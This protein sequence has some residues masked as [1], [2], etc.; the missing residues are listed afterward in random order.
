M[1]LVIGWCL[2]RVASIHTFSQRVWI[3]LYLILYGQNHG[4]RVQAF[5]LSFFQNH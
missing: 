4:V 1:D 2:E 3:K 5:T